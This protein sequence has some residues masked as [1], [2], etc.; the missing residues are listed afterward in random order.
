MKKVL[1]TFM[2]VFYLAIASG[3]GVHLH[4]CMGKLVDWSLVKSEKKACGF[5]GMEKKETAKKSCCK[6]VQ[7]QAK[8]DQAQ[9]TN[10]QIYKFEQQVFILPSLK[11]IT[12]ESTPL[13]STIAYEI[14]SN[15]PPLGQQLPLF[16]KNCTYRI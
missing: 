10:A 1:L 6:D 11:P 5:C 7:H 4:Y 15:A 8:V 14:N 12:A 16:I 13:V 2:A 3:A 9:K